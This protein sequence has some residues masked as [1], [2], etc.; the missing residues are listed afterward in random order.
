[1]LSPQ[2][3]DAFS[4]L[5]ERLADR[6]D[7]EEATRWRWRSPTHLP[8]HVPAERK[9]A[10]DLCAA[11][12]LIGDSLPALT[13]TEEEVAALGALFNEPA[14]AT[15]V[16]WCAASVWRRDVRLAGLLAIG[17]ARPALREPI[18]RVA[19]DRVVEGPL[20]D[21]LGCAPLLGSG[22]D[23]AR[24]ENAEARARLE[25]L[26]WEAGASALEVPALGKWLWGSRD[27]FEAMIRG[28]AHGA[29]R[30]RVLAARCLE[31]SVCGMPPMTDPQLVGTTLQTLQPLLLHPDPMVWVH[32]A[33]AL[34]RLTGKIEQL[35]GNLLDWSLGDSQVLRQRAITAFASLPAERL[36]FLASQ[37]VAIL[38]APDD[39]GWVLAAVA[40]ATPYL[41]FER[42]ALWARL[43]RRILEG[44]GG[45]IARAPWPAGSR[46][47]GAADRR[48]R[49][50]RSRSARSARWPAARRR[51]RS[52][53][54]AAGS[55]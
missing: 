32:A 3:L 11:A 12:D 16:A 44:D 41:F 8:A 38:D 54:S 36:K 43:A 5:A 2:I 20:L 47:S 14:A 33:R 27:T 9:L 25:I 26:I 40:A 30:G 23:L 6:P 46:R 55:T 31:V 29:L 35:E 4:L 49:R 39:E 21:A 24:P 10:E 42:R 7:L 34:G 15:L 50:S 18:A 52:I 28:P 22:V 37:L 13:R 1:M 19:R 53:S 45:A 51:R 17:A 48:P